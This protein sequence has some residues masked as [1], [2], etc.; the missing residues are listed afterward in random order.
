[1]DRKEAEQLEYLTVTMRSVFEIQEIREKWL[2]LQD[3]V[4]GGKWFV[5]SEFPTVGLNRGD[6]MGARIVFFGGRPTIGRG[7]VL[8]PKEA[9]EAILEIVA[10]AREEGY[11]S[12]KLIDHLDKMRLKL[13]RYS[14]VRIQ[15]VYR[16]P[17]DA[18]L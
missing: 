3:I 17:S 2:T 18:L 5:E 10:R 7:I 9:H 15:H 13:D 8:H 16:H 4:R 14:N 11:P 1:M 6:I 12:S